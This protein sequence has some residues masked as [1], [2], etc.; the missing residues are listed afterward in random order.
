MTDR[1]PPLSDVFLNRG[2]QLKQPQSV[3]DYRAAFANLRGNFF[4]LELKLLDQLSIA[5]GF[6]DRIEILALE[7]F[8]ERQLEDIA[9]VRLAHDDGH[10]RQPEQLRRAPPP[11]TR[12]E[13]Q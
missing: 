4:L 7:V 10:L 6:L 13:F 5:L 2:S 3:G 8:D 9:V 12:D 11:F 1:K